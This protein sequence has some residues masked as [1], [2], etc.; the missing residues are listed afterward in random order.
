M[1]AGLVNDPNHEYADTGQN[2]AG[3]RPCCLQLR[4]HHALA[5]AKQ[6]PQI[7][8]NKQKA[9]GDP[10]EHDWRH[11]NI[12]WVAKRMMKAR[13]RREITISRVKDLLGVICLHISLNKFRFD[14]ICYSLYSKLE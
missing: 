3:Q 9:C 5:P 1:T 14:S 11:E 12:Q 8:Q 4:A 2:A 6:R 13:R 10:H 7:G